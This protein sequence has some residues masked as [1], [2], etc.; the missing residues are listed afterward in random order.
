MSHSNEKEKIHSI[1]LRNFGGHFVLTFR[2]H[3]SLLCASLQIVCILFSLELLLLFCWKYFSLVLYLFALVSYD[4]MSIWLP[5]IETIYSAVKPAA[6]DPTNT[7]RGNE[8]DWERERVW[9]NKKKNWTQEE[10]SENKDR[11]YCRMRVINLKW[12]LKRKNN[13]Y[14]TY[15]KYLME[16]NCSKCI[17]IMRMCLCIR[18]IWSWR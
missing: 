7:E 1:S 12:T 9:W 11:L 8:R 3:F 15:Y 2:S 6:D 4:G 10:K 16:N 17:F 18:W 13:K 5:C 14:R